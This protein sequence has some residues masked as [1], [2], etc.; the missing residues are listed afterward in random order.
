MVPI[1]SILLPSGD[2]ST[3]WESGPVFVW[4]FQGKESNVA[5]LIGSAR[6]ALAL[7]DSS[8]DHDESI[9]RLAIQFWNHMLGIGPDCANRLTMEDYKEEKQEGVLDELLPHSLSDREA[10]FSWSAFPLITF[11]ISPQQRAY[12]LHK[13]ASDRGE[14]SHEYVQK[15]RIKSNPIHLQ[16]EDT[17]NYE[18]V[19]GINKMWSLRGRPDCGLLFGG[20]YQ[21]LSGDLAHAVRFLEGEP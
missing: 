2:I 5:I 1:Y 7:L 14:K 11:S 10:V 12:H 6:N 8:P 17:W 19:K 3:H 20:E 4:E 21:I 18:P 9:E 13:I 16:A 15:S